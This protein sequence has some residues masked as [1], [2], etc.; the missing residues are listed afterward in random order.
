MDLADIARQALAAREFSVTVG[1]AHAPR[2]LTL[3]VPTQHQT[4]LAARRAGLHQAQPDAAATL[5]LERSIQASAVV[6]WH[7]VQVGDVLPESEAA[8][9]P[10]PFAPGAVELLLDAQPEW[11]ELALQALISRIAAR[12]AVQE[13]GAKN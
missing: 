13:A 7:G 6:G 5:V 10:L 2:H 12:H 8:A 4:A 1:P 11:A 3:R 9:E